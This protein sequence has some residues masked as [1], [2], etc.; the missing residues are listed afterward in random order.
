VTARDADSVVVQTVLGALRVRGQ[1][2]P[3]PQVTLAIRPERVE[4]RLTEGAGRENEFPARVEHVIYAGAETHYELKLG[5][6]VLRAEIMNTRNS[7]PVFEAGQ[8][9]VAHLPAAALI[10][11][12]D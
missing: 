4:L 1:P 5:E 6:Q 7:S 2:P 8:D 11:L 10:L 3:K 9:A 12:D